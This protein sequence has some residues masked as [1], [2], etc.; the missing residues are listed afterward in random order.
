MK[1]IS[2]AILLAASVAAVAAAENGHENAAANLFLKM[3]QP[4]MEALD[5]SSALKWHETFTQEFYKKSARVSPLSSFSDHSSTALKSSPASP[6]VPQRVCQGFC[7]AAMVECEDH[8]HTLPRI[9]QW[10]C[11]PACESTA[12]LCNKACPGVQI[13]MTLPTISG[14]VDGLLLQALATVCNTLSN[15]PP[16]LMAVYTP[17]DNAENDD[18]LDQPYEVTPGGVGAAVA[19]KESLAPYGTVIDSITDWWGGFEASI[20]PFAALIVQPNDG[21]KASG[22]RAPGK[23]TSTPC[24]PKI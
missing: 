1:P 21:T 20:P 12:S 15:P 4:Q 5:A 9:L 2:C 13:K 3:V 18:K 10:G 11:K 17:K 6:G 23:A 14:R 19:F 8:C 7:T 24:I 16:G 22:A